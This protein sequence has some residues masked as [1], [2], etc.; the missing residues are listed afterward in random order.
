MRLDGQ[1][2]PPSHA[3]ATIFFS[4]SC[5][6]PTTSKSQAAEEPGANQHVSPL[7][8]RQ[9][10]W[11]S[12]GVRQRDLPSSFAFPV[13][14][15]VTLSNFRPATYITGA[16]YNEENIHRTLYANSKT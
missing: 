12:G 9:G 11:R 1:V 16:V 7:S 13:N 4:A 10:T 14:N 3:G 2:T 8:L 6:L 15:N 5:S